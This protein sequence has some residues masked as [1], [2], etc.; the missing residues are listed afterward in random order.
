ME[1]KTISIRIPEAL[2]QELKKLAEKDHRTLSSYIEM[3]V[4]KSITEAN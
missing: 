2:H 4:L 3:L 1:K